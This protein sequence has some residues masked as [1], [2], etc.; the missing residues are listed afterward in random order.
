LADTFFHGDDC[1]DPRHLELRARQYYGTEVGSLKMSKQ[2]FT[3][4][5]IESLGAKAIATTSAGLA[6]P[7]GYPD[8][9]ALP[10]E[11]LITA[12]GDIARPSGARAASC[13]AFL[14]GL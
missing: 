6:W 14:Q 9:N 5:L 11:Q 10:V 13:Q 7:R 2:I 1:E 3:S 8:G 4:R 12:S